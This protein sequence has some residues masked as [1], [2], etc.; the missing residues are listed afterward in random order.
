MIKMQH[1]IID[2]SWIEIFELYASNENTYTKSKVLTFGG[3]IFGAIDRNIP[4]SL[5]MQIVEIAFTLNKCED[6]KQVM[7]LNK[8][9]S[10][11]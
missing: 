1:V 9:F 7:A 8:Q 11:I 5:L 4:C 10:S 6:I 3:Q 2:K